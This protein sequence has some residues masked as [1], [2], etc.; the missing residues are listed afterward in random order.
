[1]G[2]TVGIVYHLRKRFVFFSVQRQAEGGPQ[3]MLWAR[4]SSVDSA[5]GGF[6]WG[7]PLPIPRLVFFLPMEGSNIDPAVK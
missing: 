7:R 5:K 4:E 6:A 3:S 2:S 1:M